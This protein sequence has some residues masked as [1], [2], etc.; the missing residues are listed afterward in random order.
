MHSIGS[1]GIG[2]KGIMGITSEQEERARLGEKR[3]EITFQGTRELREL[4]GE[5]FRENFYGNI[6]RT[7]LRNKG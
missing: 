1:N 6:W 4:F 5:H 3:A 7:E 2:S